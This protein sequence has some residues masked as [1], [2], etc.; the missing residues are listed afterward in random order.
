MTSSEMSSRRE[1]EAVIRARNI[2]RGQKV[3]LTEIMSLAQQLKAEKAF[4]LARRLLGRARQDSALNDD[5]E[6]RLKIVQQYALCTYKDTELPADAR[7]DRAF[8]I[9]KETGEDLHTTKNQETLGIAGAICKRRWEMDGQ[10]QHLERSLAYYLRGYREGITGDYGYTG[11]NAA[12]V[13][14]LLADQ[15]TAAVR[16]SGGTS[17]NAIRRCQEARGIRENIVATLPDLPKE[18]GREWLGKEWWFLATI[19][20][21]CFGL[22]QYQEAAD[23]LKMALALPEIPE[24]QFESTVRKLTYMAQL[25]CENSG[26]LQ[27]LRESPAFKLL[28]DLFAINPEAL[29]GTLA[30]KIGLALSGGG[31]RASLFHIGVLAK[32]AEYDALRHVEVLSCVSGGSIIGAHYYLEVRRLL[33]AKTDAAITRQD[34]IDLVKRIAQTFLAGVQRNIR[35]RVASDW[36]SNLKMIFKPSYSRTERVGELFETE[37]Y[38]QVEDGEGKEPRWLNQLFVQ[39]VDAPENFTPRNGNWRRAA[40]VPIL[41]L[42]ATT[43]N[44]GHN[45][46][47]TASW[48]GEPPAGITSE[49]DGNDRLRRLYYGQAPEQF[50]N[51][52]LGHA[53]AASACVPGLFEPLV[54]DGLYPDRLVRLVDG[55]VNDN[56]GI[57]GLLEEGC[58]ILLI[59]DA[60]GQMESQNYPKSGLLSV[61]LRS[62]SILMARVREAEFLEVDARH[63]SSLL[64]AFMFVHLKKDLNVQPIDWI[65]CEEPFDPGDEKFAEVISGTMTSYGLPK[66]V[67]RLLAAV[68]TDLDSFND[69]EASALMA[70]GYRMTEGEF[71]SYIKKFLPGSEDRVDWPFL[72]IDQVI[73][74]T[75]DRESEHRQLLKI[76]KVA[77]SKGFKVWKLKPGLQVLGVLAVAGLLG[78]LYKVCSWAWSFSLITVGG[79]VKAIIAVVAIAIIGPIVVKAIN[80]RKTLSEI[81]IGIGTALFGFAAAR[82][83]LRFFDPLY[84]KLGQMGSTEKKG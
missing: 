47:F 23:W 57:G 1:S 18:N 60:S 56:Q 79:T 84:L 37:I 69:Q 7:L 73:N 44:T 36:R 32:L 64:R 39:P 41:L 15:E 20:E 52:R 53:V 77:E 74:A 14:D 24:W 45:W 46:Q 59:S 26:D 3:S 28:C 29:R 38:G 30:G 40:K 72:E 71:A 54:L 34:Y 6:L 11:I 68:R 25:S 42:N 21:A 78:L 66:E 65:T 5:W 12:F 49:I 22:G 70:S 80:Y 35:T 61:P 13:L 16:R 75:P 55:G 58:N 9:L 48:M 63:R 17:E 76:L 83:H 8:E 4:S 27:A 31:F 19:A 62:N 10:I 82:L 50:Q 67:Q 43:L 81:G 51:I 2:L 33:Q